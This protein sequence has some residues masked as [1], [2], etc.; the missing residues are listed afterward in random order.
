MTNFLNPANCSR[1]TAFRTLTL[2]PSLYEKGLTVLGALVGQKLALEYFGV[3]PV[4]D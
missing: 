1:L 3:V 2:L 4:Y